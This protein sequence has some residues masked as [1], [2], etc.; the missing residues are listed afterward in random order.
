MYC[1]IVDFDAYE[2]W[3]NVN[4]PH[5]SDPPAIRRSTLVLDLDG[6]LLCAA[7]WVALFDNPIDSDQTRIVI[8][9]GAMRFLADICPHFKSIVVCTKAKENYAA[10]C[11]QHLNKVLASKYDFPD[12]I[13]Y[14][15][16]RENTITV[17]GV[18]FKDLKSIPNIGPLENVVLLDDEPWITIDS[19]ARNVVQVPKYKIGSDERYFEYLDSLTP[20]LKFLARV[21]DIPHTLDTMRQSWVSEGFAKQDDFFSVLLDRS[22][23]ELLGFQ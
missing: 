5:V 14:V 2:A 23:N 12:A 19:Q 16:A 17:N 22:S 15:S 20:L 1:R 7:P 13:S 9:P 21:D 8:R 11:V 3:L 6:T 18:H 4:L 10:K